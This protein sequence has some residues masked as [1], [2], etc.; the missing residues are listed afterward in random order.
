MKFRDYFNKFLSGILS[1]VMGILVF[2]ALWQVFTRYVLGNPST[3]TDEFLRYA[4]VWMA[5]L[6]SVY[7]FNGRQHLA[8]VFLRN[9]FTGP[10]QL[11]VLIMTDILIIAFAATAMVKGGITLSMRTYHEI[12]PVLGLSMGIVY[13]I[14]P[15]TGILMI[16]VK[17]SDIFTNITNWMKGKHIWI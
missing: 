15:I 14:I 7:A 3:F 16:I 9:K 12:T 4:M 11:I 5:M 10:K 17:I 13:S 1:I 6:G 8:L 2:F